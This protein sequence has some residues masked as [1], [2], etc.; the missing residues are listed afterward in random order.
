M[1]ERMNEEFGRGTHVMRIFP[2][3]AS[4]LRLVRILTVEMY[5]N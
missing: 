3:T 5:E 2:K 4:C 1:L